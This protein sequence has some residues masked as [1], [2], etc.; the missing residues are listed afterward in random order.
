MKVRCPL[1]PGEVFE[2]VLVEAPSFVSR[3][4]TR[5]VLELVAGAPV[6]LEPPDASGTEVVEASPEEWAS[7]RAAGFELRA[8]TSRS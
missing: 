6:Q 7:L 3:T 1:L 5:T 4:E 2:A 8:A